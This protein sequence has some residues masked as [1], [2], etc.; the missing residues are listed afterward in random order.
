[1]KKVTAIVVCCLT[2]LLLV[3][4]GCK[5]QIPEL[6]IAP[7]DTV[8]FE[9]VILPMLQTNCAKSGCH[10]AATRAD[11]YQLDSYANIVRRGVNAGSANSSKIYEVIAEDNPASRMPPPPNA[12]LTATQQALIAKWIN[13]G[14]RN[15][16]GCGS[17][18]D[19]LT[20]TYN[21]KVKPIL[22][23]YCYAC[24][25][26]TATSGAGIKLDSYD[27]LRAFVDPGT[28]L[29]TITHAPGA[30]PMPKGAPK[31]NACNIATLRKWIDAG[32]PNN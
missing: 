13:Q 6:P 23:T 32:A 30:S 5:H 4:F 11:G 31:L 18:C 25:S 7:G 16:S 12:P 19:T 1:M 9:S 17:A 3:Q 29:E 24:H 21:A 20:F 27:E 14:A 15:T 8:C 28:L 22:Q 26:G 2:M 10:D